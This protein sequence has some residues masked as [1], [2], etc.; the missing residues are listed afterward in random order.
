MRVITGTARGRKLKSPKGLNT[1]P[2]TD[3]VKEALFNILGQDIVDIYFLDLFAGSGAIGIEALSRGASGVVFVEKE[4]QALKVLKEN[5]TLTGFSEI[6]Q[7]FNNDVLKALEVLAQQNYKFDYV[8]MDPPYLKDFE[9]NTLTK[10]SNL[11]L[12]NKQAVVIVERSKRD[13]LPERVED[14]HLLREEKYG[15]TV[16]SFYKTGN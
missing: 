16:I 9:I 15:D 5:V 13:T 4:A 10:L 7:V 12:L 11:K 2:T 14:L 8:F 1:R 3:R 6:A